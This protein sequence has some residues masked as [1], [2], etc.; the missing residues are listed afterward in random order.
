LYRQDLS[1]LWRWEEKLVN[2]LEEPQGIPKTLPFPK[3]TNQKRLIGNKNSRVEG[4]N[5]K[6]N[7]TSR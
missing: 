3:Y 5:E 2:E 4:R 7:K 6:T 1:H